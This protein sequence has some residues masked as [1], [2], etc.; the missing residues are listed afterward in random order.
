MG[1]IFRTSVGFVAILASVSFVG[2]RWNARGGVF[3]PVPSSKQASSSSSW[4]VVTGANSGLGFSVAQGLSSLGFHVIMG[5]RNVGAGE[6]AKRRFTHKKGEVVVLELDQSSLA[7]VRSFSANVKKQIGNDSLDALVLN[8]GIW[9]NQG[10]SK[11]G[12]PLTAQ[13]NHYAGFLL[14]NLLLPKMNDDRGRIVIGKAT[15]TSFFEYLFFDFF[16]LV[17]SLMSKSAVDFRN[18]LLLQNSSLMEGR[19]DQ[20]YGTSKLFNI[21]HA[22]ALSKRTKVKVNSV[23][24]AKI[25]EFS[26]LTTLFSILAFS[27]QICIVKKMSLY[28]QGLSQITLHR[29]FM[30]SLEFPRMTRPNRPCFLQLRSNLLVN[31]IMGCYQEHLQP[32]SQKISTWK[33][34]CGKKAKRLQNNE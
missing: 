16:V 12:I 26:P 27:K 14:A 13:V 17:S 32:R 15:L 10:P 29:S 31:F 22:Q 23:V 20:L 33:K 11:D 18:D 7:S 2:T 8:A 9:A 21:L 19:G 4:A 28:R 1:W 34:C 30:A 5:V 24:G 25:E 6:E 3:D